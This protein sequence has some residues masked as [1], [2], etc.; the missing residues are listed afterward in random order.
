[1]NL[2]VDVERLLLAHKA[3][4]A[5][6]LA[7]RAPGGYWT[8]QIGS[9]PLAT[10]AA[11]SALVAAHSRD[12]D[13]ALPETAVS[14]GQVIQQL[15]QGDLSELLLESVHWLARRQNADGGW[16]DCDGAQSSIAATMMVQAA[17][18]LT[19]IPGKY[20]DLMVRADQFVTAQGGVAGLRRRYGR[21]K[22]FL[23]PILANCALAGMATWRQVSTLHFEWLSLPQRWQREIHAP[24][25]RYAEPVVMAVGLAKFHHDPPRNPLTRLIRRSLRSRTLA[26][27]ERLQAEDD[28]FLASPLSTAFVVMSLASIGCQEHAIVER[29]I[30]FLLSSV[31]ADSSWSVTANLATL[32]T[33]LV[34]DS[35]AAESSASRAMRWNDQQGGERLAA[36]DRRASN[37]AYWQDTATAHET[38][39]EHS[40]DQAIG[41]S[42]HRAAEGA[43]ADNADL[44]S[45]RCLDW[46]LKGQQ[47][48]LDVLTD[49]PAGGWG[50]SDAAGA[51]P[52]TTATAGA[53]VA[54]ESFCR[55]NAALNRLR[56]E[57]AARKG[58]DW[59]LA[60]QNK[61]GGWP[62]YYCDDSGV[63]LTA[64]AL[65]ALACWQRYWQMEL[66]GKSD[67]SQSGWIAQIGP[68]IERALHYLG[69]QQQ[70]DGSFIPVWF[71]NEHHADDHNPVLGTAQVLAACA[72]LERLDSKVAKQAASW[73]VASQHTGG[74]WGPPRAPVDYSGAEKEGGYRSWRENDALAK[75]CSVEETSA[76]VSALFALAASNPALERSV[77]RGLSWLTNAVEHE[78]LR[79]P[80][81]IGF[82]FSKIWYY[83]RLYP[84]ALA[85]GALSRAVGALAPATPAVTSVR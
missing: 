9:S 53:L 67:S 13:D 47:S 81:I 4:R 25:A 82:Y 32:N 41:E 85:A 60:L 44:F 43:T 78:G 29:G 65:R 48:R 23:A 51:V 15:V 38:V 54:L 84:L 26:H 40:P 46:L 36:T 39:T 73:L 3:V 74:G 52:N 18:R 10:A 77:S 6:L 19:G 22:A 11:V 70:E 21:D 33:T 34:L 68:A 59:L 42:D 30:E 35:L 57:L 45:D 27:L 17:F 20:A 12:S 14:D 72:D 56:V 75:F 2:E 7:E 28:S 61:D 80:A 83:E 1:M 8:G 69:S 79:R 58:V 49:A 5:E 71:G 37:A 55:N 76:A 16:G 66:R 62:T 31:R 50:D 64:H 63:D 24:T